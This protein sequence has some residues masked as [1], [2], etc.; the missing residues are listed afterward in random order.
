MANVIACVVALLIILWEGGREC[1]PEYPV[2]STLQVLGW[3]LVLLLWVKARRRWTRVLALV[4]TLCSV[5]LFDYG[6]L[7]QTRGY[8]KP[9]WGVEHLMALDVEASL[10]H[11]EEVERLCQE[12]QGFDLDVY[13]RNLALAQQ[14]RLADELNHYRQYGTDG[15]LMPV[16]DKGNYFTFSAASEAWWAVGDLTMAEHAT[17]LGMIF[18]PRHTG[19]RSLKRLAEIAL[20]KGD[21]A[22]A[23]KYLRLLAQT[24]VHRD[25]AQRR[26]DNADEGMQALQALHALQIDSPT[27]TDTLRLQGEARL[28]L[29]NTLDAQ[30][31]RSGIARDYLLCYDLLDKDMVSLADDIERYGCP[32]K[33]RAYEEAMLIIM[34]SRPEMREQWQPLVRVETFEEFQAF[35]HALGQS[36]GQLPALRKRFGNT[37][38]Y[39]MLKKNG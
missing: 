1:L 35:N 2:S 8:G 37:Y 28:C 27:T 14:G 39:Y 19:S 15:L 18:S 12:D 23:D 32:T 36:Q 9:E 38:W 10:G 13:Y 4:I 31:S 25:W 17:I 33:N 22:G 29:R 7:P 21:K 34:S 16:N 5:Y 6:L 11:W 20:A 30:P 3:S 24:A 26:L